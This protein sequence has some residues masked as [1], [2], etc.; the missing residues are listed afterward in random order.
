MK[1]SEAKRPW[2]PQTMHRELTSLQGALSSL[3][4]YS[5]GP[6]DVSI[7]L[8]ESSLW[9]NYLAAWNHR[10]IAASPSNQAAA[11]SADIV[12]AL[13]LTQDKELRIYLMMIWLTACRKGDLLKVQKDLVELNPTSGVLMVKIVDGKTVKIAKQQYHIVTVVPPCWL[14]E[15]ITFLSALPKRQ[16]F[17]FPKDRLESLIPRILKQANPS[18]DGCR[19]V[20]RG[21][22]QT[23]ASDPLVSEATVQKLTAHTNPQMLHR[24]L[25]WGKFRG[26]CHQLSVEAARNLDP[27]YKRKL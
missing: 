16:V 20:R 25:E 8:Q 4:T 13:T 3:S 7:R 6:Q 21:A 1:K 5:H 10:A 14:Q 19:S 2:L 24:Y 11:S 12:K 22:A 23:V 18:L 9:R 26:N 15:F 27:E 17:L